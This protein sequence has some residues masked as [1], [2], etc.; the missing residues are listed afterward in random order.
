MALII[1]HWNTNS[2][3]DFGVC[4]LFTCAFQAYPFHLLYVRFDC[5]QK[6]CYAMAPKIII[7]C[8]LI[9]ITTQIYPQHGIITSLDFNQLF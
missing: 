2:G 8:T 9:A 7:P 5:I 3:H 6:T 1:P 4:H